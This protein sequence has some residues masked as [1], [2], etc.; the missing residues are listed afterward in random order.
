V[1]EQRVGRIYRLGQQAPIDV[2]NLVAG[3]RIEAPSRG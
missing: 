1:L 2:Y 3:L